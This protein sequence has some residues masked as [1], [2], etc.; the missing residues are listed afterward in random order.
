MPLAFVRGI[1]RSPLNSPQKGPV[2]REMFPFDDFFMEFME[3]ISVPIVL[4]GMYC[5]SFM[6]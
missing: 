1:H 3:W 5:Y 6:P 2:T 4:C